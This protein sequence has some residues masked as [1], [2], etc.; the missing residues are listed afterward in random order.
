MPGGRGNI[1]LLAIAPTGVYVIDAKAARGELR[2]GRRLFGNDKLIVA[3]RN[4]AKFSCGLARQLAVVRHALAGAGLSE[5]EVTG[6]LCFPRTRLPMLGAG[7]IQG[8][9][10]LRPRAL[11]RRL[12]RDGPLAPR[13]IE[14]LAEALSA[15]LPEA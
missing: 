5:V 13:A 10:A 8:H 2:V 7:E 12:Q 3:G 6:V 15:S 14:L 11:A 4:R 1:D 9:Q